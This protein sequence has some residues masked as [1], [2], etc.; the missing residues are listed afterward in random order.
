MKRSER[1]HLKTNEVAT[2]IM[3]VANFLENR[4][5]EIKFVAVALGIILV[6]LSG[7]IY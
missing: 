3:R 5:R 2:T 7:Y 6:G 4:A 1:K